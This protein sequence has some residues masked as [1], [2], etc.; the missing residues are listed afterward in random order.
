MQRS[1]QNKFA[2]HRKNLSLSFICSSYNAFERKSSDTSFVFYS[3][4]KG[5]LTPICMNLCCLSIQRLLQFFLYMKIAITHCFLLR[6]QSGLFCV[7]VGVFCVPLVPTLF[8]LSNLKKV[9]SFQPCLVEI[10]II[11]KEQLCLRKYDIIVQ[12]TNILKKYFVN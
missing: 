7:F 4:N 10:K 5:F 1:L 2:H 12:I 6:L 9:L 3:I 8:E 11:L